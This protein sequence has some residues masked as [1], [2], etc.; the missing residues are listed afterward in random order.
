MREIET[1]AITETVKTLAIAAA[2]ELPDEMVTALLKALK[3]EKSASGKEILKQLIDN[4]YIAKN[5]R[6]PICQDT[7]L[8][9]VFLEIGQDA[10]I[11]GGNIVNAVNDG[12]AKASSEGFLRRS[13]VADP[14]IRKN[15]DNN[16]PAIIHTEI[17]PGDKIKI[18]YMSKGG[19]C[20]N[21]SAYKM[22]KPT[23]NFD[24]VEKFVVDTVVNAGANP[25][26]PIIVGVGIGGNLEQSAILAKKALLRR[27]DL[28]SSDKRTAAMEKDLLDMV[29]ATGIGPQGLGGTVTALTVHI[30]T[31]PCHIASMPVTVNIDC[32]AHR[33]KE[34]VI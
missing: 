23:A 16:T 18:T 20:E 5:E 3:A 31:A 28:A 26:P 15:T 33:V 8:A 6:Y 12:V 19:G 7:G 13:V 21:V 27:V 9:L 25:C 10:H 17:V 29:N 14:F 32:H 30:E 2:Y 1:K 4:S 24:E 22:L 34:A 11:T